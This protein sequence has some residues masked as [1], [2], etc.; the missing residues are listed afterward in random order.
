MFYSF[1]N[2]KIMSQRD[3]RQW[4]RTLLALGT[5]ISPYISLV[6]PRIFPGA[7]LPENF[8]A[9]WIYIAPFSW[10][11]SEN[12][13]L[14]E[15]PRFSIGSPPILESHDTTTC[16]C[17]FVALKT[18]ASCMMDGLLVGRYSNTIVHFLILHEN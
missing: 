13:I 2:V 10:I 12:S 1:L 4:C 7:P 8:N 14:Y 3:G 6:S 5:R 16:Q 9:L 15:V 17:N 18:D 11:F